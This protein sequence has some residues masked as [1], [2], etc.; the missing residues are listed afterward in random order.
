MIKQGEDRE[1]RVEGKKQEEEKE[2][3]Q[4]NDKLL[5]WEDN[6]K[7]LSADTGLM[8]SDSACCRLFIQGSTFAAASWAWSNSSCRPEALDD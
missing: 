3:E 5:R 8:G 7:R 4:G 2:K 1:M 6:L